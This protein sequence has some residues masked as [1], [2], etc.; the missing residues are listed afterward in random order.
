[1]ED[2]KRICGM[3]ALPS[4]MWLTLVHQQATL[5]SLKAG[6]RSTRPEYP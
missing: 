4:K 5:K 1:M 2:E 6:M 3:T